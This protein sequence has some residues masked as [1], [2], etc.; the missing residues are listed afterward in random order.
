MV[1]SLFSYIVG[2]FLSIPL[3]FM[4]LI[5]SINPLIINEITSIESNVLLNLSLIPLIKV[6]LEDKFREKLHP[7]FVTGFVD[8]EGCFF[9][10]INRQK[11]N[12]LGWQVRATFKIG[13]HSKDLPL[14]K[15]IQSFFKG[16]GSITVESNR[17][18]ANYLVQD[19]NSITNIILPHFDNFPLESAKKIDF[20]LWK[21]CLL[22]IINKEHLTREGLEK[23]VCLKE[24]INLGLPEELRNSFPNII[25]IARPQYIVNEGPLNPYWIA[26]FSEGDSSF[27]FSISANKVYASYEIGL[28]KREEPLLLKIKE[29]FGSK[30]SIYSYGPQTSAMYRIK[31]TPDLN[32]LIISH[33]DNYNLS[34][35]KLQNYLIWR[36]MVVLLTNKEHL[37][38]EGLA[39]LKL[40]RSTLNKI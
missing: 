3:I 30:G 28:H 38:S 21:Q 5:L 6:P 14:L 11:S 26:G 36:E 16:V 15:D 35:V 40:L 12:K 9:I 39:K 8:A 37:T 10:G 4:S 31:A 20:D 17:N 18:V 32:I 27:T 29:F 24:V 7:F 25:S 22:L 13:L 33:F 1:L 19:I 34:G 2:L 23:I